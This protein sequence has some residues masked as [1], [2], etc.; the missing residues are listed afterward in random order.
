MILTMFSPCM[1]RLG[2]SAA[3]YTVFDTNLGVLKN[4]SLKL[5]QTVQVMTGLL[6]L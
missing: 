2:G 4:T 6:Y 5:P 1:L 3:D